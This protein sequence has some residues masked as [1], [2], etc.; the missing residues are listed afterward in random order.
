MRNVAI[1][2][3]KSTTIKENV[4]RLNVIEWSKPFHQI[5]QHNCCR[6]TLSLLA[7]FSMFGCV[8]SSMLYFFAHCFLLSCESCN[9][10]KMFS[11][12]LF[13]FCQK[14]IC[15]IYAAVYS[16][17]TAFGI[18]SFLLPKVMWSITSPYHRA[19][20][21]YHGL[22]HYIISWC[23]FPLRLKLVFIFI[24][25]SSTSCFVNELISCFVN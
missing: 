18:G 14:G 9:L 6:D 12:C 11:L 13:L 7:L 15:F 24:I 1:L 19:D 3:T 16:A 8:S 17:P 20:R 21:I 2:S 23:C 5:W 4:N 25:D 22:W 10:V